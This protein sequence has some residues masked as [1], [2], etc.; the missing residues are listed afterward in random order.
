MSPALVSADKRIGNMLKPN[1]TFKN[2]AD[3][4]DEH[5]I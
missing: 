1:N 2:K 3:T 4:N 5:N